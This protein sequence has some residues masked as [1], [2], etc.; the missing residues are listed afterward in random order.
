MS[1]WRTLAGALAVALALGVAVPALGGS[2]PSVGV[3]SYNI[4]D[5]I[6][7]ARD[8][9]RLARNTLSQA[10]RKSE[11]LL[12]QADKTTD[13]KKK[14][15]L[16]QEVA[17]IL[18][19]SVTL[20]RQIEDLEESLE[21]LSVKRD[22]LLTAQRLAEEQR[23][24]SVAKETVV[25]YAAA[26]AG[27]AGASEENWPDYESD[28]QVVT[29]ALLTLK[30][31]SELWRS[32]S[33]ATELLL[34]IKSVE[35]QF[36]SITSVV[37]HIQFIK[38][39][40]AYPPD[41]VVD[42][43]IWADLELEKMGVNAIAGLV[44]KSV[45][46]AIDEYF[47]DHPTEGIV[48]AALVKSFVDTAFTVVT[49]EPGTTP[50]GFAVDKGLEIIDEYLK[51]RAEKDDVL[52]EVVGGAKL[53]AKLQEIGV[54]DQQDIVGFMSVNGMSAN[55]MMTSEE[56]FSVD[57]GRKITLVNTLLQLKS[58]QQTG[59]SQ[60]ATRQS[61]ADLIKNF[62]DTP[63]SV[64]DSVTGRTLDYGDFTQ[65]VAFELGVKGWTAP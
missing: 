33:D 55:G 23:A 63:V 22:A 58:E 20:K 34:A 50:Y 18:Q 4:D 46:V 37:D 17:M 13:L 48:N 2:Q 51:F 11:S 16:L 43:R 45:D 8:A 12:R 24:Q 39:L 52:S 62:E 61:L 49:A 15:A 1:G 60:T 42:A 54:I 40:G 27:E 21:K 59:K 47:E 56:A 36:R 53:Y 57:T 44:E 7:Q 14:L 3:V 26:V 25:T 32:A 6:S 5:Q 41:Q 29:A 9:L 10:T 64:L 19:T 65:G 28:R 31:D 35:G 38:I 30:Q